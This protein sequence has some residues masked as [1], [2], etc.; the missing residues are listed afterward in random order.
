MSRIVLVHWNEAEGRELTRRL[1]SLG[2]PA[3]LVDKPGQLRKAV[4]ETPDAFLID[5][6]RRPSDGRQ[7]A[8]WVRTSKSYRQ[9]P[10]VFVDGDPE[11]VAALKR[12]LPDATY[13]S[14]G[15]LKTALPKALARPVGTPIVPPSS[16]YTG[17]R[18]VEK[19]GVKP[20]T[21]VALVGA[22]KG[23]AESLQPTP[24]GVK[25]TAKPTRESDLFLVFVRSGRELVTML[26]RLA[27]D[28]DRQTVWFFWPKQASAVKTDLNGNRVRE[29]GLATGWVDFKICSIDDT[30][31]ALAFKRRK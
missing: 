3:E 9:V 1:A 21:K 10:I 26:Q 19:L 30:W 16:L 2:H 7:V 5:L 31:S 14:W 11:K 17:R 8:M 23:F 6:S 15:R 22:P 12:L 18:N 20:D 24:P 13:T 27:R 4:S 28:V 29:T 25:F